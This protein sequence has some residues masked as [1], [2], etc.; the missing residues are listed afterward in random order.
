MAKKNVC[1]MD[2]DGNPI[3]CITGK[4]YK[5]K[6]RC[7]THYQQWWR[8]QPE[9]RADGCKTKLFSKERKTRAD[10]CRPHEQLALTTRSQAA[11]DKTLARFLCAIEPDWIYGCWMWR[12]R[13][14]DGYGKFHAGGPWLAHRFAYVWFY[15][16]HARGKTLDH[17]CNRPLCVRPDHM[18]VVTGTVNTK[19]R[20]AR[21]FAP[22]GDIPVSS[23]MDVWAKA[24][25]LPYGDPAWW[26]ALPVS[27]PSED[28]PKVTWV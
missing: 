11:Q 23:E 4:D 17:T 1:A 7:T 24:N 10:Y 6:G 8:K 21:A 5:G 25:G 13:P 16:G 2:G 26:E 27:P 15:G 14:D 3:T 12:E 9:C 19:R 28:A 22:A 20:D 18:Q